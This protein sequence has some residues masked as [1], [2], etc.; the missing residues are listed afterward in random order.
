MIIRTIYIF[1]SGTS[2]NTKCVFLFFFSIGIEFFN[3][4]SKKI[5]LLKIRG[6]CFLL[7]VDFQGQLMKQVSLLLI[8]YWCCF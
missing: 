7:R 3:W 2:P 6:L 5:S 8:V 1:V 4:I